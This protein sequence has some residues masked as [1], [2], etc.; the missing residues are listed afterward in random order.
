MQAMGNING[1]KSDP[2]PNP[3]A[4]PLLYFFIYIPIRSI[5]IMALAIIDAIAI[6]YVIIVVKN[7]SMYPIIG[8]IDAK[9]ISEI[10]T[11][12]ALSI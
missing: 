5:I 8:I 11:G 7:D 4:V 1:I 10:T 6:G 9:P 12:A 3:I 2:I